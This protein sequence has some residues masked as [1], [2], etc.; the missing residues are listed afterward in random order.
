MQVIIIKDGTVPMAVAKVLRTDGPFDVQKHIEA[1][2][3][4]S[5]AHQFVEAFEVPDETRFLGVTWDEFM[6]F[7]VQ[8]YTTLGDALNELDEGAT[9]EAI[10]DSNIDGQHWSVTYD[11]GEN[12]SYGHVFD[13]RF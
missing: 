5:D 7:Q 3:P 8:S 11:P 1:N 9:G 4:N 13:I 10:K 12:E 2:D 6:G